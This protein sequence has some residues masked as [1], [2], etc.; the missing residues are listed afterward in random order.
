MVS[1]IAVV[2]NMGQKFSFKDDMPKTTVTLTLEIKDG[3]DNIPNLAEVI[4]SPLEFE[5][6]PIQPGLITQK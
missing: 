3:H 6:K 2:K 1:F 5:I 4:N